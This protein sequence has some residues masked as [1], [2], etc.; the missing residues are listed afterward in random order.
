[1]TALWNLSRTTLTDASGAPQVGA[2]AYFYNVGTL[3]PQTVYSDSGLGNALDQPVLAN[4]AG[5]FPAVFLSPSPGVYRNRVT[6]AYDVPLW[7][8]DG[9]S[10]PQSADYIPPTAGSTDP[11]LLARTGDVKAKYGTGSESGWVRMNGRSIGSSSSGASERANDDTADLFSFLY[12]ADINLA[13]SGGRGANAASDYAA[14]KTITLPSARDRGLIGLGDMGNSDIGLIADALVDGGKTNTTLGA[15]IGVS[16]VALTIAQM[17]SHPHTATFAGDL[18]PT[19]R[20]DLLVVTGDG[21]FS[22]P[23][24]GNG[25]SDYTARTEPASA[26]TPTGTVTVAPNG[27]GQ[28]HTN[29]P[30]GLFVTFYLKL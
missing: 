1:M 26:G 17:P 21:G 28:A 12:N 6:D 15:T 29:M 23:A 25:P 24:D 9:I 2:K 19:H 3:T 16:T 7:D 11:N 20:H 27:G 14:N 18:M 30:P 10:V 22:R 4:A 13:V 5:V 8:D